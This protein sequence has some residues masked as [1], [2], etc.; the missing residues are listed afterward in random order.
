MED[1]GDVFVGPDAPE[2]DV[3]GEFVGEDGGYRREISLLR[4]RKLGQR[5]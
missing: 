5:C 1:A 2:G 4:Q 3:S